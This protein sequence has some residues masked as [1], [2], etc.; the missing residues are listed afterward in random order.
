[1]CD[2]PGIQTRPGGALF[3]IPTTRLPFSIQRRI[4]LA[5]RGIGNR[6]PFCDSP[7]SGHR[8]D[9]SAAVVMLRPS[10]KQNRAWAA[11]SLAG[12]PPVAGL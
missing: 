1:M 3:P 5:Q 9:F 8:W 10:A 11:N 6:L 12:G 7:D 2:Q 4:F